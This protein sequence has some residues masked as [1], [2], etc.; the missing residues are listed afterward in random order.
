[1]KSVVTLLA[2]VVGVAIGAMAIVYGE[3]DDSPGLQG[4]GALMILCMI[5]FGVRTF[6]QKNRREAQ[7]KHSVHRPEDDPD[8]HD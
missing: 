8:M 3:G 2:L 4:L 6:R 5:A 7:A 1:M